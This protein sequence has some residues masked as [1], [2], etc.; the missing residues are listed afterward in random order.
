LKPDLKEDHVMKPFDVLVVGGSGFVGTKVMK[1]A[2]AAGVN[3]AVTYS[4]HPVVCPVR[5]FQIHLGD[6]RSIE[7][8]IRT[9]QPRVI[10]YCAVPPPASSAEAHEI[11][12]V[13][14][15]R[16]ILSVLDP[17]TQCRFIYLSTNAVFSGKDGPYAEIAIPDNLHVW[18]ISLLTQYTQSLLHTRLY[19]VDEQLEAVFCQD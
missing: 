1:A 16:R 19:N 6:P 2:Q 14:G 3:V 12:S 4:T 15:V 10:L 18:D 11:V 9:T 5:S 8:C 17:S 7:D 13:E